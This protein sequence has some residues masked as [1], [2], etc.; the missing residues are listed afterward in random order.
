M[1]INSR[2]LEGIWNF[3]SQQG[4]QWFAPSK[5]AVLLTL[6]NSRNT[7]HLREV[8]ST[9]EDSGVLAVRLAGCSPHRY[10]LLKEVTYEELEC[11]FPPTGRQKAEMEVGRNAKRE[12]KRNEKR[13]Y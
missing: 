3:V 11:L 10:M 8:I 12:A 5:Q 6:L 2:K 4:T 9:L 13:Y 1:H 7:A